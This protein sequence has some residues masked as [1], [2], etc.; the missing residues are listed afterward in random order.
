MNKLIN[1]KNLFLQKRFIEDLNIIDEGLCII[2]SLKNILN[3]HEQNYFVSY[4]MIGFYMFGRKPEKRELTN[5][6]C[7]FDNLKNN[8]IIVV[9]EEL[10]SNMFCCDLSKL[11]YESGEYYSNIEYDELFAI[12]N[13]ASNI[14]KYK[15]FRYYSFL[16]GSFNRSNTISDKYKGKIG[17]IPLDVMSETLNIS[18]KSIINY[19]NILEDN[20]LLFIVRHKDFYQN[21]DN[22]GKSTLQ[23]IQ[24]TYSRYRDRNLASEYSSAI[25]GYKYIMQDKGIKTKE[26]N[27][28]RGLAQKFNAFCKGKVYDEETIKSLYVYCYEYNEVKEKE[29]KEEIAKGYSPVQPGYKDMSVFDDYMFIFTE[30]GE[31]T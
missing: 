6:K 11:N 31:S 17:G 5:I 12:M 23:E 4:D 22:N 3:Q 27:N 8:D 18:K 1:N 14:S 28:K 19:N 26:A 24:N 15:L 16:V 30:N 2:A 21:K 7:G 29:Y 13:I 10:S 25:Y 20:K 9:K